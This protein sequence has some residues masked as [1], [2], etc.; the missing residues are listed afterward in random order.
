M[1]AEFPVR[2]ITCNKQIGGL[3]RKKYFD[4]MDTQPN[5][6]VLVPTDMEEI[7]VEGS[8]VSKI[9]NEIGVKRYCCKKTFLTYS[10]Q[11]LIEINQ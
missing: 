8:N 6:E 7:S 9:L 10:K 1:A 11:L 5:K 4:Y 2:C 3:L